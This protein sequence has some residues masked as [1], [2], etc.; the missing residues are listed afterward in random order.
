LISGVF[1]PGEHLRQEDIAHRFGIS[2]GPARE[3]LNRLATE[4]FI[5]LRPRRGYVVQTLDP[6]EAEDIFD[7]RVMLEERAGYLA[8]KRRTGKDVEEVGRL[9][10]LM[11]ELQEGEPFD[12]A[13]WAVAHRA[14]HER[15]VE[16]CGRKHL[17]KMLLLL[18]DSVERYVRFEV[19]MLTKVST[20]HRD[21]FEAF[22]RG[23]AEAVGRLSKDHCENIAKSLIK[24]LKEERRE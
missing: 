17:Q 18:R 7:I 13:R 8:T 5:E 21:I 11:E 6:D 1:K 4:G 2:R 3:A 23:D 9:L 15:L 16:S 22:K 12:I 10:G 20:G 24:R 14:F 19:A